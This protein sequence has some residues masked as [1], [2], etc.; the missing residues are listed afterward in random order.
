[1]CVRETDRQRGW[2]WSPFLFQREETETRPSKDFPGTCPVHTQG[3]RILTHV[4]AAW[5]PF[6]PKCSLIP[7]KKAPDSL[8]SEDLADKT[9]SSL[10]S[11][12]TSSSSANFPKYL[13]PK[14]SLSRCR[15]LQRWLPSSSGYNS[16]KGLTIRRTFILWPEYKGSRWSIMSYVLWGISV[17]VLKFIWPSPCSRLGFPSYQ[18]LER[19]QGHTPRGTAVQS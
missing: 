3:P 2:A 16:Q 10:F 17:Q 18:S 15:T 4:N 11:S 8:L 1:M 13:I 9:C 5:T 19:K 6:L 12:T 14:P 7:T